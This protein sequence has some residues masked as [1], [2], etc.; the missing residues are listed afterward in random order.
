MQY[1]YNAKGNIFNTS[2]DGIVTE[3]VTLLAEETLCC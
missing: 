2:L 1:K 3:K